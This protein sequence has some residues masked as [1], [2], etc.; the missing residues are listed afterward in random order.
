LTG[1]EVTAYVEADLD[2]RPPETLVMLTMP[3]PGAQEA[4]SETGAPGLSRMTGDLTGRVTAPGIAVST[5]MSFC[6]LYWARISLWTSAVVVRRTGRATYAVPFGP[7]ST[8]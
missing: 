1:V 4:S 5:I 3:L 6:A 2:R 7:S 8:R